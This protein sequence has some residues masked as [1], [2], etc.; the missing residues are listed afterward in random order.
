[1]GEGA[2]VAWGPV[3]LL[4]DGPLARLRD[5]EVRL[6]PRRA[7]EHLEGA[8]AVDRARGARDGHDEPPRHATKR[9]A[10]AARRS[11]WA[12]RARRL[13]GWWKFSRSR[14]V[15]YPNTEVE[16]WVAVNP[17]NPD[18]LVGGW[19]QDRWNDGGAKSNLAGV[20]FDGGRTWRQVVIPK[21]TVCSGG[22][23][24]TRTDFQ[25]ASDPW[26]TFSADGDTDAWLLTSKDGGET[27][28]EA[29]VTPRSFDMRK[30]P[31]A[32][33]LFTGESID[34]GAGASDFEPCFTA[35]KWRDPDTVVAT[36]APELEQA[37]PW[38]AA[39]PAKG[40]RSL[41]PADRHAAGSSLW[42]STEGG[43]AE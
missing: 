40:D 7:P 3:G 8:D 26:V 1:V 11:P 10:E 27:W 20:S 35:T 34:L 2:D 31:Q 38:R 39:V 41:L 19:Q 16:P 24:E 42:N 33:G 25:R 9:S 18:N 36:T 43:H 6:D 17:K 23:A 14:R 4:D 21:I 30:A 22:T 29:R 37:R 12:G 15:N 13:T 32:R 28:A 5:D